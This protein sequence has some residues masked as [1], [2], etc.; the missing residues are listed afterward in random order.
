MHFIDGVAYCTE[1]QVC[2][3][4]NYV[5]YME[6]SC[7]IRLTV[8]WSELGK[9]NY[10]LHQGFVD[11]PKI[12]EPLQILGTNGVIWS[13]FQG[14]E[15]WFWSDLWTSCYMAFNA[16]CMWTDTNFCTWGEK[17]QYIWWT[18]SEPFAQIFVFLCYS[19]THN[20][21]VNGI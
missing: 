14:E 10:I 6:H 4:L 15:L 5:A 20:D 17:L 16:Y 9:T 18:Y 7:V 12:K 8:L 11:F 2:C 21:H 1:G 19:S 3:L 13:R